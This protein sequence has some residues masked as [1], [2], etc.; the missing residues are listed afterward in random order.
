MAMK[1]KMKKMTER[2][3]GLLKPLGFVRRKATWNRKS[4]SLIDV[5]DLQVSKAGDTVTINSGIVDKD[6][7]EICWGKQLPIFVREPFCTV[8]SRVGQL[9]AEKKIFGGL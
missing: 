9:T 1:M 3:D 6:V 4:D 2:L 8:R 7:H 5:V